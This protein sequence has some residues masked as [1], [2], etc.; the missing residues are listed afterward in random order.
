ML[1]WVVM[2]TDLTINQRLRQFIWSSVLYPLWPLI[3]RAFNFLHQSNSEPYRQPYHLGWLAPGQTIE[4]LKGHLAHQGFGNHFVAWTDSG[5]VLSWRKLVS[6]SRQYHI[7]VFN[8]GEIRGHFE[9]TP[10][11]SAIKHFLGRGME[12]RANELKTFL[13]TIITSQ[14][15]L[16]QVKHSRL[17][18][19][20]GFGLQR[21]SMPKTY[22]APFI[23]RA[24]LGLISRLS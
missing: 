16:S 20:I 3:E 4:S 12:P 18:E 9:V 11:A 14:K 5:Q 6:F 19:Q 17:Y 2:F 15:Y 7:R 13:G 22:Q 21:R 8:D 10:E 23:T 24:V 1:E